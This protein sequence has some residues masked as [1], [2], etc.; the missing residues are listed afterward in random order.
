MAE[1]K[2]RNTRRKVSRS[3][4]TGLSA[5]CVFSISFSEPC[6]GNQKQSTGTCL[7]DDL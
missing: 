4:Y 2:Q 3:N 7:P 6:F 1:Y 5:L